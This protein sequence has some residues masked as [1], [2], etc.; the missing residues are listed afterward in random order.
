MFTTTILVRFGDLDAAG[1]AYYP[2]LVNY[3]HESFEDFF[4][5]HVGRPYPEVYGEGI[6]FPTVKVEMEFL[7]PVHYGD[8]VDVTVIVERVGR[9]SVQIRYEGAVKGRPV[10]QARNVAVVVD[11]RSFRPIQIPPWLRERFEA[12]M[13]S[14]ANTAEPARFPGDPR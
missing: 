3:L 6:G 4:E 14:P 9:T 5:G 2:N 1:I 10:F 12:A 7:A 13:G 11:M 8:R